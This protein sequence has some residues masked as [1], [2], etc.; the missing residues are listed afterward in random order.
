M[1]R[2]YIR[3]IFD[4]LGLL[5]AMRRL[6]T[7][8]EIILGKTYDVRI[9]KTCPSVYIGSYQAGYS[10]CPAGLNEKSIVY[11]FGLGEDISFDLGMIEKFGCKVFGSDPTPK[12]LEYLGKLQLPASF[13]YLDYAIADYDGE[14]ELFFPKNEN[15]VSLLSGDDGNRDGRSQRFKCCTVRTFMDMLGHEHIDLLKI[16]IKGPE[17]GIIQQ[18]LKTGVSFDQLIV[19]YTPEIFPDGNKK[20]MESIKL[21]ESYGYFVF[22]VSDDGRN[23]SII[24]KGE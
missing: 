6:R 1:V 4:Y 17:F 19:E 16:D 5:K 8:I 9:A 13:K 15:H 3:N 22:D 11:S 20:V 18:L 24:K 10:I 2:N 23:I 21:L 14:L 12:S 7:K